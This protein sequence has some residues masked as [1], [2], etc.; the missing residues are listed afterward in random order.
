MGNRAGQMAI[1]ATVTTMTPHKDKNCI[2]PP[3]SVPVPLSGSGFIFT[4]PTPTPNATLSSCAGRHPTAVGL[5]ATGGHSGGQINIHSIHRATYT[6][7]VT[8]K[9]TTPGAPPKR[10]EPISDD[11]IANGTNS[12][13]DKGNGHGGKCR[14]RLEVI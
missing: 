4:Q 9:W 6:T 11:P 14:L 10:E 8:T 7:E 3:A 5:E 12:T 2:P 13:T 1:N